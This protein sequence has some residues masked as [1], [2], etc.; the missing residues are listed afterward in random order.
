MIGSVRI[1]GAGFINFTL[2]DEWLTDQVNGIVAAGPRF[3]HADLGHGATV[4]VEFVSA[5]PTGPLP[6]ASGRGGSL[7]DSLARV[8]AAAGYVVQR[9]YYVNDHGNQVNVFG[10]S[11]LARYRQAFGLEAQVPAHGYQGEYV[12]ELGRHLK[13]TEGDKYLQM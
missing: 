7:G 4:Q 12:V 13:E 6:A 10:Q 11:L 8:L 5:N 9:E 1:A 3:G 2:S